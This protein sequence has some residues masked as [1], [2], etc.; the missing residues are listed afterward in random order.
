[1][2]N[3]VKLYR[4]PTLTDAEREAIGYYIGTGGPDTVDATLRTLLARTG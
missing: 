4:Q 1:M 3:I 2:K